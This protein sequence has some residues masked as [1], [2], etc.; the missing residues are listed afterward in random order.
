MG[1][2]QQARPAPVQEA[3][4]NPDEPRDRRGRWT[5][6]GDGASEISPFP[7]P[8]LGSAPPPLVQTLPHH[9]QSE[10]SAYEVLGQNPDRRS[11]ARFVTT[12]IRWSRPRNSHPLRE[13]SVQ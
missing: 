5:R 2:Q 1:T 8:G 12:V 9:P 3:N 13:S 10:P 11:D 4:F 6:A 7:A